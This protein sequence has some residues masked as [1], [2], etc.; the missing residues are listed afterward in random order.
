MRSE[1]VVTTDH[2]CIEWR[3]GTAKDPHDSIQKRELDHSDPARREWHGVFGGNSVA[4]SLER[5]RAWALLLSPNTTDPTSTDLAALIAGNGQQFD[6]LLAAVERLEAQLAEQQSAGSEPIQVG[7][8]YWTCKYGETH[9]AS[10]VCCRSSA[11][12]GVAKQNAESGPVAV[13]A[14]V[15]PIPRVEHWAGEVIV[16]SLAPKD[17]T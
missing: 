1:K 8:G 10:E 15:P 16:S 14:T 9:H 4:V 6:A 13:A 2:G 17:Q 5:I 3:F 7:G 11:G 12:S